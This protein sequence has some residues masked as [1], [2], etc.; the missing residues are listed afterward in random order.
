M[1]EH[2]VLTRFNIAT[3]GREMAIRNSPGWLARRFDLFERYCLPSMAAQNAEGFTW[4]IYFDEATP[5]EF[6]R[7]IKAAQ[8]VTP[9]VPH[10]VRVREMSQVAGDIAAL[11]QPGTRRV[12]TTRLDNDDA[13]SQDYLAQ[14]RIAADDAGDGT[15]IN[16]RHG[17]ALRAGRVYGAADDSNPFASLVEKV[18]DLRTIWSVPHHLLSKT[19]SVKQVN[20]KPLW[21][22]VVHG[23]NVTNRIKG[24]RLGSAKVLASFNMR[25]STPLVRSDR[26]AILLD[27]LVF[28]PLRSLRELIITTLKP[29]RVLIRGDSLR[30]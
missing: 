15:V 9:F 30:S 29:V 24:K 27:R 17:V 20:T 2:F 18:D 26:G 12:V 7:R 14:V 23:D 10:F 5:D 8:I 16:F 28:Y 1:L 21:L 22:Q 4:L 11:L 25:P 19:F 6:R 13:I 3:P